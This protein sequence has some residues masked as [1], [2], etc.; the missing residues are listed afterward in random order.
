MTDSRAMLVETVEPLCEAIREFVDLLDSGDP[1]PLVEPY[2]RLSEWPRDVLSERGRPFAVILT[3]SGGPYV[4][5]QAEGLWP[6][7]LVGHWGASRVVRHDPCL[8][9]FLDYFIS[10]RDDS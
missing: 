6:A 7:K 3:E 9:R 4:E 1:D 10:R 2:G 5:V 8:S